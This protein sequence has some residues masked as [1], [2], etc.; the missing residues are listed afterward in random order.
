MCFFSVIDSWDG[1]DAQIFDINIFFDRKVTVIGVFQKST[2]KI[3]SS[4]KKNGNLYAKPIFEK[5]RF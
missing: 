2:L 4:F 1:K 3:P 5:N